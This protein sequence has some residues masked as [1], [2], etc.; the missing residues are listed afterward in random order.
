[1][2]TNEAHARVFIDAQ[3]A[4]QGWDTKNANAVRYEVT[5][6]DGTAKAQATFDA[7]LA[8]TFS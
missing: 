4:E 1:M 5:L 7:L 8:K 6:D 3:L 2:T